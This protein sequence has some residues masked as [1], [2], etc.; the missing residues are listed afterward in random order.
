MVDLSRIGKREELKPRPGD[1]PHWQRLH[2][3]CYLGFRPSKKGGKGTW[4]G[5]AFDQ[6]TVKYRRK[7]LGSY[8][9]LAGNDVFAAA[10]RDAEAFAQQ[11]SSGGTRA[12]KIETVADACRS[13]LRDR[14]VSSGEVG[15]L[16]R[17]VFSDPIA[18]VKLD[19][20]RR[21]HLLEWRKRLEAKPAPITRNKGGETLTRPR[22]AASVNRDM[23]PLRAALMRVLP[24][25][26]P[27]TDA[28]WGEALKPLS[29]AN[30]S[31]GLYLD[32]DQRRKLL[33]AVE[34]EALPFVRAM[35]LLPLRPG[36]LAKLTAGD[37]DARTKTLAIG[38]DKAGAQRK[39]QLPANISEFLAVQCRDKLQFAPLFM[40]ADGSLWNKD[41]WKIPINRAVAAACLPSGTTAYVLR[42]SVLTDLVLAGLPILTVAQLSGTSVQMI[43]KHYGHLV[44]DAAS[45]ALAGLAL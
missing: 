31:R 15:M 38:L 28:A 35:T 4:F 14:P 18:A 19:K 39:I 22:S 32:R 37:F 27:G 43:E 3:G 9:D 20:L 29:G 34:E 16:G 10:K 40:R 5:R 33:A 1:E 24:P 41:A 8:G 30:K 12:E 17:H 2:A 36:A 42:H 23:V 11:V 21:H 26:A 7:A 25:G 6:D 13:Y 44:G 45:E